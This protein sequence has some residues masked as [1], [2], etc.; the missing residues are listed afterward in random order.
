MG[1]NNETLLKFHFCK[2]YIQHNLINYIF[3][4]YVKILISIS[5]FLLPA[6]RPG[7]G[8]YKMPDV[9]A[10]VRPFVTFYKRLHTS[11]FVYEHK[12]TKLTPKFYVNKGMC[13]LIFGRHSCF[14]I[15]FFIFKNPLTLA[16]L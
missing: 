4:H 6:H 15:F 2:T 1:V 5:F 9:C 13:V 16:V 14:L 7:T 11:S 3:T 10:C 8:D 12:F